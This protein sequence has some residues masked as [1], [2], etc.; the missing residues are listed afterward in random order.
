MAVAAPSQEPAQVQNVQTVN[1]EADAELK[2]KANDSDDDLTDISI[3]SD[4]K[5]LQEVREAE[6]G[7]KQ[8]GTKKET[9]KETKKEKREKKELKAKTLAGLG[10]KS[11]NKAK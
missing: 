10:N 11:S 3:C 8:T 5:D 6:T 1:M 4:Q 2:R 9:G 7:D